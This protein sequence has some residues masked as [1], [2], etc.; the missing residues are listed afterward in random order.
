MG[1]DRFYIVDAYIPPSD[2]KALEEIAKAWQQCPKG[3][4]SMRVG[5]LNDDSDK[6]L[7]DER[8]MVIAKKV[9]DMD[10]VCMTRQFGQQRRHRVR[11]RWTWRMRRRGRWISSDPDIFSR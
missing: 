2:L 4:M 3:C 7:V 6:A 10:L 1:R 11:G 9:D 5:D 8:G